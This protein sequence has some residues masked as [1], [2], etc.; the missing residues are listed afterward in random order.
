MKE[1]Y[2]K[3]FESSGKVE[4]YLSF[5]SNVRQEQ[6]EKGDHAGLYMGDRNHTEAE[7]GGGVRQAYQPFD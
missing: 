2:W 1:R 5:V 3:Q 6:T 4:D 7:P